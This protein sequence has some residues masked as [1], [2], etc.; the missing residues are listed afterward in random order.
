M[1]DHAI[2]SCWR[3]A[4]KYSMIP[5]FFDVIAKIR[6]DFTAAKRLKHP[7]VI[8]QKGMT[9]LFLGE[10]QFHTL[11]VERR[12]WIMENCSASVAYDQL[13]RG[14]GQKYLFESYYDAFQFKMRFGSR[15]LPR[16]QDC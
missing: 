7:H 11:N 16:A 8:E 13:P 15:V 14:A 1:A 5:E 4:A 9:R 12:L 10:D 6:T 3:M 2:F